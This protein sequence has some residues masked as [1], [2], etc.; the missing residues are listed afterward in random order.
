[1]QL[2]KSYFQIK[3]H[4]STSPLHC[5]VIPDAKRVAKMDNSRSTII[6]AAFMALPKYKRGAQGPQKQQ[7]Y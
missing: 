6:L 7:E 5:S 2:I 1:M 4:D 3:P